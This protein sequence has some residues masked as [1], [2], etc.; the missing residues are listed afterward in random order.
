MGVIGRLGSTDSEETL[1]R[2]RR[3]E[4][5]DM[6]RNPP[7]GFPRITPYLLYEDLDAAIKWLVRVFGFAERLRMEG[8]DGKALHAEIVLADG[9]VM[10]G[11]PGPEYQNPTHRGG[12]TQLVNVYVDD[13]DAHFHRAQAAGA[14]IVRELADQFYGDRTYAAADLEGHQ[15]T[16][17]QH[18]IDVR[19]EDMHP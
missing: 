5:A 6:V 12:V 15:W 9:L 17:S 18:V 16:F 13:V 10:M 1:N 2:G 3:P 4:E 7:E 14:H 19:P 8:P 11:H